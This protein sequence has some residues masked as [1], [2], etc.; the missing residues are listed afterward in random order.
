V[1]SFFDE[2]ALEFLDRFLAFFSGDANTTTSRFTLTLL[3]GGNL[4][5]SGKRKIVENHDSQKVEEPRAKLIET[6]TQ[7]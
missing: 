6:S 4:I 3:H 1:N 2:L 7:G 5:H